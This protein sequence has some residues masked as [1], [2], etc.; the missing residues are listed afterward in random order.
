MVDVP[1]CAALKPAWYAWISG[2][3]GTWN[4]DRPKSHTMPEISHTSCH[5]NWSLYFDCLFECLTE[6]INRVNGLIFPNEVY[7]GWCSLVAFLRVSKLNC[8]SIALI[9]L[10]TKS[11]VWSRL[12]QWLTVNFWS[13]V[14]GTL[15]NIFAGKLCLPTFKIVSAPMNEAHSIK[16]WN[17]KPHQNVR[18][19][20]K[21]R[22]WLQ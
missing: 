1:R 10:I 16:W 15:K 18:M 5:N 14:V 11:G 2:T 20:H 4:T 21:C 3:H 9:V 8:T 13:K 17:V 19:L 7:F 6:F 12:I 22:T